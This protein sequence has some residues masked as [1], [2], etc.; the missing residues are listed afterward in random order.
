MKE[1]EKVLEYVKILMKEFNTIIFIML[2]AMALTYVG[3]PIFT[4]LFIIALGLLAYKII[5]VNTFVNKLEDILKEEA[6]IATKEDDL[7]KCH[8]ELKKVSSSEKELNENVTNTDIFDSNEEKIFDT[9]EETET[10]EKVQEEVVAEKI[11]EPVKQEIVETKQE[12]VQEQE[13]IKEV[14]EKE[15][16]VEITTI[17]KV[18]EEI[19]EKNYVHNFDYVEQ[20]DFVYS[21]EDL[22]EVISEKTKEEFTEIENKQ[23][24]LKKQ[25]TTKRSVSKEKEEVVKEE[26]K[27][28]IDITKYIRKLPKGRKASEKAKALALSYGYEL[29]EGETFVA[30]K[31]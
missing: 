22:P 9:F 26:I 6:K 1:N 12:I 17:D 27:D 24:I 16:Q 18:I 28:D 7:I 20:S 15:T 4:L 3:H 25:K 13:E 2:I 14:I 10:V 31:K 21:K 8:R 23:E 19:T 5:K 11:S 30:P 29:K